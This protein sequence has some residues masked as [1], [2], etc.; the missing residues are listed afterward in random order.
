MYY[1]AIGPSSEVKASPHV[2]M[3]LANLF[4]N[5]G[6][7][8]QAHAAVPGGQERGMQWSRPYLEGRCQFGRAIGIW[9]WLP[10]AV[11]IADHH[12]IGT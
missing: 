3:N 4:M 12:C 5:D 2:Y 11:P 1:A 6:E 9:P 8:N 10:E 7:D